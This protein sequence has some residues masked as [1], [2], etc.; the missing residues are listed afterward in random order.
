VPL[1]FMTVR[2]ILGHQISSKRFRFVLFSAGGAEQAERCGRI[3]NV[4]FAPPFWIFFCIMMCRMWGDL[5]FGAWMWSQ[6]GSLAAFGQFFV[7]FGASFVW[8]SYE[9]NSIRGQDDCSFFSL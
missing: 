2:M 4:F 1:I 5:F 9:R 8:H 7:V 3:F 6:A